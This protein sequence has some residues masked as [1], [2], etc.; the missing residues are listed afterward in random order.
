[1]AK[2][3]VIVA[4]LLII[5]A[6]GPDATA[7]SKFTFLKIKGKPVEMKTATI[8]LRNIDT[9]TINPSIGSCHPKRATVESS[10]PQTKARTMATANSL[11]K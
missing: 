2:Y 1:M 3:I 9:P 5:V 8:I 7:G 11:R 10:P 4:T 6:K